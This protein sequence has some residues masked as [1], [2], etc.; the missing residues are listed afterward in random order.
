M[1]SEE[2][3]VEDAPRREDMT[4]LDERLHEFNAAAGGVDD[5]RRLAVFVRDARG[6]LVALA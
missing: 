5:G 1:T 3:R 2:L 6:E 4:L